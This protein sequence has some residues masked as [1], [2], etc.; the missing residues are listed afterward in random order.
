MKQISITDVTIK[1]SGKSAGYQLSFREKIEL[2]KLLDRL[3][4]DVIE[5]NPVENIKV[6]SLLIKSVCSAVKESAVAVP[7]GMDESNIDAVWA[8][9]G[10]ANHPRLQVQLPVSA[11]QMEYLA[12]K[13]P[14]AMIELIGTLVSKCK[15]LC[16]DVE[17]I[18]EDAT[19]SDTQFLS[20]AIKTAIAA[21]ATTVTVCDT[22][23]TSLP[24]EF[25]DF[26]EN[27]TANIPELSGVRLGV[28]CSDI[29]S[30]ADGCAV[31]SIRGGAVEIK[32]AAYGDNTV[33]LANIV[34]IL[35]AKADVLDT[36]TTVNAT[37]IKRITDQ[38]D[39]MCRTNRSKNSPF[40]SGVQ[41]EGESYLSEHDDLTAVAKAV[42]LMG[43]ELSDEDNVKVFEEFRKI[44]AKKKTVSEKELDAIVASAALQVP[45]TYK[46]DSYVINTGN[47]ISA[48]ANV[49]MAEDGK[50]TEG[51]SI[52]DGPVDAAFLAIEQ[53]VGR[54]FE[55]D[56]FQIQ[57]VTEG[58]EAMGESVVKLRSSGK[59]YSGRGISTDILGASINAYINALN[60]IVY[61]EKEN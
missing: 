50:M 14:A 3:R 41:S 16:A 23:G 30:M 48:T 57:A 42:A 54:H 61:E 40:D 36:V 37:Q 31:A 43:Y 32:T 38:I 15:A 59:L 5:L 21:G 46:L 39:W 4:V 7:V 49:K 25:E 2:A 55:L 47:I 52:G 44:A 28:C 27:I 56:D 35:S 12:G 53:I 33:S 34:K 58:R 10:E 45:P 24:S 9:M 11:V 19:R 22:A 60:K 51:I 8:A 20:E 26:I 1:Q 13:K 18:A 6:D 17:F 29:L